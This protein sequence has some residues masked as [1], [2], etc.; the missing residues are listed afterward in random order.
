M[1]N[2]ITLFKA[3]F[4]KPLLLGAMLMWYANTNVIACTAYFTSFDSAGVTF[5]VNN[6]TGNYSSWS[7]DFGDGNS[8]SS[9]WNHYYATAGNYVACLTLFD[10]VGNICDTYCDSITVNKNYCYPNFSTVDSGMTIYFMDYSWSN[11]NINSW[12]WNFGDSTTSSLQSPNHTYTDTGWH[13]VCLTI[14]TDSSCT[15]TYCQ[16]VHAGD[17][18]DATFWYQS[19]MNTINFYSNSDSTNTTYLWDFGD[20]TTSTSPNPVHTYPNGTGQYYVCLTTTNTLTSCT[21]SYCQWISYSSACTAYFYSYADSAGGNFDNVMSFY[22]Y[23]Q[24]TDTYFWD[25]GDGTSSSDQSPTHSYSNAG[26]YT[27]CLIASSSST[28]CSDTFCQT[29]YVGDLSGLYGY[30]SGT[31]YLDINGNCV[32]DSGEV[33]IPNM[34]VSLSGNQW[35]GTYTDANG[36]YT[37]GELPGTYNIYVYANYY[38]NYTQVCPASSFTVTVTTGQTVSGKDFYLKPKGTGQDLSAY[39]Y[40]WR[41]RPGFTSYSY[42][43]YCNDGGTTMSGTVEL[44]HDA[45]LVLSTS[46]SLYNWYHQ[47]PDNYNAGTRTATWN[48]SNLLPGEC[49]YIAVSLDV[50]S[51]VALGTMV[52]NSVTV[53]PTSGDATV[54]NNS[55]TCVDSV[56]GSFDPNDKH[57][58]PEGVGAEGYIDPSTTEIS[59]TINFQNTGTAEAYTVV[60]KDTLDASVFDMNTVSA[61]GAKHN[62]TADVQDNTMK[63]TFNNIMLPDSNTNE[64]ASHG[65]V[66]YTVKL[67]SGLPIGTQIKNSASIYFDFNDPVKTNTTVNTLGFPLGIKAV[68]AGS[69]KMNILP[70]PFAENTNI[71]YSL[72]KNAVVSLEVFNVLGEKV[73]TIMSSQNQNAGSY[74]FKLNS[75]DLNLTENFYLVKLSID[76]I[77]TTKKVLMVK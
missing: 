10:S 68:A 1:K 21:N 34:Y 12:S 14:T 46:D 39:L 58:V 13:N 48:Y 56:R 66:T 73:R 43:S 15:N 24:N 54:G 5:F 44:V 27:V 37:F 40:C 11:A 62:F 17:I 42:I 3:R 22:N 26:I 59:Y 29:I 32:Q 67:K 72:Q 25:F 19:N 55:A 61:L 23:S 74:S 41:F 71:N 28:S 70:N 77:V 45:N 75:K 49:R 31:V 64:P 16:T 60:V 50:P 69:G 38:F 6:S 47:T 20:S 33:G 4:L 36:N 57:A 18:C 65:F 8:D 51:T 52:T 2:T 30:V 63:F 9:Y 53:L 76:G 35:D 7:L